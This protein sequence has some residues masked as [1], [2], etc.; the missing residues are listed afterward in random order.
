MVKKFWQRASSL[1][2]HPSR[3]RME[4]SDI[5]PHLIRASFGPHQSSL[6]TASRSVRPFMRTPQQR[7]PMLFNGADNP[8]KLPRSLGGSGPYPKHMA[9]WAHPTEPPNGIT[10]GWAVLAGLMNV[11]RQ[12][13]RSIDRQTNRPTDRPCYSVYS[14]TPL[15]YIASW[16]C[17]AV[18]KCGFMLEHRQHWLNMHTR[19]VEEGRYQVATAEFRESVDA[20]TAD[21]QGHCWPGESWGPDPQPLQGWLEISINLMRT[22]VTWGYPRLCTLQY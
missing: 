15:S 2:C 8:Q 18:W 9:S 21:G 3:P 7:L 14:N 16:R 19:R 12:R 5:D 1:S 20:L 22:F 13:D 11:N 4:S 6:H 17:S 10:I